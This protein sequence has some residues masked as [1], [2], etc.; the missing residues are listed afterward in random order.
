MGRTALH[1]I[2]STTRL[3]ATSS[4]SDL[5]LIRALINCGADANIKDEV[6]YD[7]HVVIS[8]I[9][10]PGAAIQQSNMPRRV[11][12]LTDKSVTLLFV[13]YDD[14]EGL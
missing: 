3:D 14:H 2:V 4:S 5:A 10:S 11:A 7:D 13:I 6:T 8:V 12:R 1:E 9:T